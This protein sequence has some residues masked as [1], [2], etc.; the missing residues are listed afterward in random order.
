ML[1]LQKLAEQALAR[2]QTLI[3]NKSDAVEIQIEM[4]NDQI[5]FNAGS[6]IHGKVHLN[7]M[8]KMFA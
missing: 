1:E 5:S 7:V 4:K 3:Q 6:K 8:K 2:A